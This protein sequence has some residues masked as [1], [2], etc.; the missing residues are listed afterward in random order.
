MHRTYSEAYAFHYPR[1][2]QAYR[3]A[4][5]AGCQHARADI[6]AT[7]ALHPEQSPY[8]GKLYAELDAIRDRLMAIGGAA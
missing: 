2:Q 4:G 5:K 3:V 1:F 8:T 7:L 6:Y